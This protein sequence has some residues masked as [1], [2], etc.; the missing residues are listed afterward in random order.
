MPSASLPVD[1]SDDAPESLPAKLISAVARKLDG[2]EHGKIII[3]VRNRVA[4]RIERH[5]SE[6]IE[7]L[8]K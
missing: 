1:R 3:D 5:D 7:R 4:W 2:L 6:I 8:E